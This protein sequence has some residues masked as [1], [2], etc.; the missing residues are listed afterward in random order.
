MSVAAGRAGGIATGIDHVAVVAAD[1]DACAADWARLGFALTPR[2][3]HRDG[4]GVTTGTGN[5]C[6]MLRQGY[7]EILAVVDAAK[8]SGTL[9]RFLSH[10]AGIHI[11]SLAVDDEE[12]ALAR[13]GRAGFETAIARS[14]REGARFAR[15]PLGEADPRLQLIRHET[16]ELV[17]REEFLTHPNH[18]VALEEVVVVDDPAAR[19]AARLA[20]AAGVPL[21]PDRATGY[22]LKM[23]AGMVRVLQPE[24][25][26]SV[27]P[28]LAVGHL[29]CIAGISLRTDD[30][31]AAVAGMGIARAVEGGWLAEAGGT[32][33]LFTS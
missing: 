19:F 17:W 15:L 16:P 13:L 10:Y 18:A 31:C 24:E 26:A 33:V 32:Q 12:A 9:A 20:R 6:A 25:A 28:G 27:F 1:L 22:A 21:G 14:E 29:P 7:V 5:V 30:G 8:P 3:V 4:A 2:A 11:L 23:G